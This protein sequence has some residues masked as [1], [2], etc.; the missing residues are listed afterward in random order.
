MR[1][2]RV[3]GART[4]SSRQEWRYVTVRRVMNAIRRA[5]FM[6]TQ[7]VVFEPNEHKLWSRI[8]QQLKYFLQGL[9]ERGFFAGEK[10]EDAFLVKCDAE[11]N[12]PERREAGE[13]VAEIRVAP[14]RPA[15][16]IVFTL[17]QQLPEGG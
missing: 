13:L 3:W 14:V 4:I 1:G 8:E 15:E 5:V 17:N 10:M 16:F 12:P 2:I 11:T 6:K 9:Y 7:W